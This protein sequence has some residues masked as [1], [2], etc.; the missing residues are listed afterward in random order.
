VAKQLVRDRLA[1]TQGDH[2]S[3]SH[4]RPNHSTSLFNLTA[5]K[6]PIVPSTTMTD[7]IEHFPD[8]K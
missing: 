1:I 2:Y 5:L 3:Y 4:M 6:P 8:E 7:S